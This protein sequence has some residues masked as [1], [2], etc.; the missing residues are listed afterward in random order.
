VQE[1][2]AVSYHACD[3]SVRKS[4]EA[5]RNPCDP[6][7]GENFLAEIVS[8]ISSLMMDILRSMV[9]LWNI[10]VMGHFS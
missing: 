8:R 1:L 6:I 9:S 5:E 10:E 3:D 2:L 4:M 7:N